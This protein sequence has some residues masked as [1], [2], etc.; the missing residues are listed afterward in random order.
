ML[1]LLEGEDDV[2][3]VLELGV[4][5]EEFRAKAGKVFVDAAVSAL[6]KDVVPGDAGGKAV[7]D[8]LH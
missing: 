7:E 8:E 6:G 1:L 5:V 3:G 2:R 4:E